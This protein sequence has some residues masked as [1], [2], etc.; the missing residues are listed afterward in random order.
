MKSGP[1]STRAGRRRSKPVWATEN[2]SPRKLE[3]RLDHLWKAH[4]WST[5]NSLLEIITRIPRLGDSVLA[6]LGI[7]QRFKQHIEQQSERM[8][9]LTQNAWRT[10]APT[11]IVL[12][13][14]LASGGPP[15]AKRALHDKSQRM[16]S[17]GGLRSKACKMR[18]E[19]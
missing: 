18:K 15:A 4:A 8:S 9:T 17:I 6:P 7:S 19:V 14:S 16:G 2:G 12:R 10:L 3:K 13:A 1:D 5:W 11:K